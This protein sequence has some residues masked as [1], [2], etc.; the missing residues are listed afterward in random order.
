LWTNIGNFL[1]HL[2]R[3]PLWVDYQLSS[4]AFGGKALAK[5]WVDTFNTGNAPNG[6]PVIHKGGLNVLDMIKPL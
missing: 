4:T 2:G 5:L 1:D 6:T 3:L